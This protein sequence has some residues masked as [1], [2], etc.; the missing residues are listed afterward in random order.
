MGSLSVKDGSKK[1]SR[2]GNVKKNYQ[3]AAF[4]ENFV[5]SPLFVHHHLEVFSAVE[6]ILFQT[7][8]QKGKKWE[9]CL[10]FSLF[11][12]ITEMGKME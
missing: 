2:L 4:K 12:L 11:E 9:P 3:K 8:Y 5:N 6:K 1:F 10:F 7:L